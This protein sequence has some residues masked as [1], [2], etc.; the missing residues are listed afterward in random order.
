MDRL[1]QAALDL[2][3]P[4]HQS[5]VLL[6][7]SPPRW[8]EYLDL[9]IPI[10]IDSSCGAWESLS[11][12]LWQSGLSSDRLLRLIDADGSVHP[13]GFEDNI[14]TPQPRGLHW[15]LALNWSHPEEGWRSRLPLW[16]RRYLVTRQKEQGHALVE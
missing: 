2:K 12:S 5:R 4:N 6:W 9:D 11:R 3:I 7:E 14:L 16:G 13:L 10:L 8:D 1:E 15:T